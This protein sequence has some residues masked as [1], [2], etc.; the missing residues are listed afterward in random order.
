MNSK[1]HKPFQ[2]VEAQKILVSIMILHRKNVILVILCKIGSY[3]LA[4][5]HFQGEILLGQY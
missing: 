4:L 1:V 2:S 3:L 5:F